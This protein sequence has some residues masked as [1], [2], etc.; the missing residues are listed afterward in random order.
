MESQYIIIISEDEE[1]MCVSQERKSGTVTIITART[2]E[3]A[4]QLFRKASTAVST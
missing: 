4:M 1:P 2:L 3:E